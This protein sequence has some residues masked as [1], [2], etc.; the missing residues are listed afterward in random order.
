MD[1][2]F[3]LGRNAF[4]YCLEFRDFGANLSRQYR[5]IPIQKLLK[6]PYYPLADPTIPYGGLPFERADGDFVIFSGGTLYK[7][8]DREY[9]EF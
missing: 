5:H 1:H 7:T 6:Q 2:A 9:G 8:L 3:W 4:D